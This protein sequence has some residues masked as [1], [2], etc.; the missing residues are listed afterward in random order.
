MTVAELAKVGAHVP[1]EVRRRLEERAVEES[2]SLS[3][4]IAEALARSVGVEPPPRPAR[5]PARNALPALAAE[6]ERL[7]QITA[8]DA[9]RVLGLSE[10]GGRH[11]LGDAVRR[12]L[13]VRR[14]VPQPGRGGRMHVYRP[15]GWEASVGAAAN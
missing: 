6:A 13:L 11:R 10:D 8:A 14:S 4:A 1:A 5:T 9:A 3:V 15:A 7:G 2:T 12:G